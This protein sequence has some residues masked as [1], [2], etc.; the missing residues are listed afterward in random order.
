MLIVHKHIALASILAPHALHSHLH[1][2]GIDIEE[3][4][5]R[6]LDNQTSQLLTALHSMIIGLPET[7]RVTVALLTCDR[8]A[9]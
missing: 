8:H 2:S 5:F 9:Y 3:Q 6:D 4:S 7:T 1:P